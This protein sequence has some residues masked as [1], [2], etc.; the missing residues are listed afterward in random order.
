MRIIVF[1]FVRFSSRIRN[2]LEGKYGVADVE[3]VLAATE[4]ISLNNVFDRRR[5][6]LRTTAGG[7]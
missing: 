6:A 5:V 7:K 4:Y 1:A 2:R 3:D